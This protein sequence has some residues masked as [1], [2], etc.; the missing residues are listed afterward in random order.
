[1]P[2]KFRPQLNFAKNSYKL[3][4]GKLT[5]IDKKQ[6]SVS[7]SFKYT[8]TRFFVLTL[9]TVTQIKMPPKIMRRGRPKGAEATVIG[10]PRKRG[11]DGT[12]KKKP[13]TFINKSA[14]EKE[15]CK[16]NIFR[17]TPYVHH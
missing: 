17:V 3:C 9:V 5:K 15:E 6:F 1:M 4:R 8:V 14:K 16:P 13:K 10:L 2:F 7:I 12:L 11:H